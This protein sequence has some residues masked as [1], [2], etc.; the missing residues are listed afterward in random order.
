[1][2]YY[3][4]KY[5]DFVEANGGGVMVTISGMMQVMNYRMDH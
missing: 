3:M 1:M 5:K 2:A 4:V